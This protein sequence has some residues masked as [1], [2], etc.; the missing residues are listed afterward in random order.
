[1]FSA[2]RLSRLSLA[3]L[4]IAAIVVDGQSPALAHSY[5][6]TR[7]GVSRWAPQQGTVEAAY[8]DALDNKLR[9][10]FS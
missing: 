7:S 2:T 8:Y 4:M 5:A 1:M 6:R 9:W 3:L 10:T